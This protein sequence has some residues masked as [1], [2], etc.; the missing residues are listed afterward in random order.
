MASPAWTVHIVLT[1]VAGTQLVDDG[2]DPRE[3]AE[4]ELDFTRRHEDVDVVGLEIRVVIIDVEPVEHE[5]RC[6]VVAPEERDSHGSRECDT[7]SEERGRQTSGHAL[8]LHPVH[9]LGVVRPCRHI[10]EARVGVAAR[11]SGRTPQHRG[12]HRTGHRLV[13]S[14][15]VWRHPGRHAGCLGPIDCLGVVLAGPDVGEAGIRVS[16]WRS[17]GPPQKRDAVL[18]IEHEVR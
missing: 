12:V 13:S 4:F 5:H 8:G 17:I 7:R 18:T 10:G 16:G 2:D 15:G 9:R 14:E 1:T 6:A 11:G 3:S